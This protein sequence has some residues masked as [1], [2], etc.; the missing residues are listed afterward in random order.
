VASISTAFYLVIKYGRERCSRCSEKQHGAENQTAVGCGIGAE[1]PALEEMLEERGVRGDHSTI[2]RWAIRFLSLLEKLPRKHK[3]GATPRARCA[4]SP[5]MGEHRHA[6][7]CMTYP[8]MCV[9]SLSTRV[10]ERLQRQGG[11]FNT[12]PVPVRFDP[13]RSGSVGMHDPQ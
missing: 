2:N 3:V 12:R 5:V 10:R 9:R 8:M 13:L 11:I 1:V 7:D 6:I 4:V